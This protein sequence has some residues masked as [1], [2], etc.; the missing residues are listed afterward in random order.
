MAS[1]IVSSIT[2]SDSHLSTSITLPD[3]PSHANGRHSNTASSNSTIFRSPFQPNVRI[4]LISTYPPKQCG[5]A[6]FAAALGKGLSELGHAVETVALVNA[7][8]EQR[9]L[10]VS[11][12]LLNGHPGSLRA[13]VQRLAHCDFVL[14]QHE[15][16]IFGGPDGDEAIE[17]IDRLNDLGV[18]V[19]STLHTVPLLPTRGQRRVLLSVLERSTVTVVMS[20]VAHRRL[21]TVYG[22]PPSLPV[23]IPHGAT[24][25]SWSDPSDP[26]TF[27]AATDSAAYDEAFNAADMWGIDAAP[28]LLTWGLLGPGKGIEHVIDALALVKNEHPNVTYTVAGV[29]H[30]NVLLHSGDVYRESLKRRA[31]EQGIADNVRF[32]ATYRTVP[33]LVQFVSSVSAVVLP[34]DSCDQVTSGVLVDAIAA[35]RPVIATSFPH[36]VEM[37]ESGAGIVVP[38]QDPD[39]LADAIRKVCQPDSLARMTTAARAISPSLSWTA[40]AQRYVTVGAGL[41]EIKQWVS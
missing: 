23:M 12:V 3:S 1:S 20:R 5:L 17:I 4:G 7:I 24:L 31:V 6:T 8:D 19:I 34:Y 11:A 39:A 15:F 22:V 26:S 38:N 2:L 40:V 25:G 33:E 28:H 10:P 21:V 35:G 29:T 36:A 16:G 27:D 37:L 9:S 30:P 14:L 13:A 32:D 41:R 18:P